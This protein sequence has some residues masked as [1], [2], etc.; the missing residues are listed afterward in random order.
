[1]AMSQT[2]GRAREAGTWPHPKPV[3]LMAA[4]LLAAATSMA[5]AF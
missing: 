2:W 1:M 3:C 5:V 4:L